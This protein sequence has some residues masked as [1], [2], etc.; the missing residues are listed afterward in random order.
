MKELVTSSG[1]HIVGESISGVGTCITLPQLDIA[2]DIGICPR[3]ALKC[4]NVLISHGHVDH[5]GAAVTHAAT[6]DLFGAPKTRFVVS[7][8]IATKLKA[9][10]DLWA[11]IQKEDLPYEVAV[12][13]PGDELRIGKFVVRP[14]ATDHVIPSQGYRVVE[15]RQ[16][17]KPEFVGKPGD[18]IGRLRKSGV[19]VTNMTEVL[20]VVY[21]GDTR[22]TVWDRVEGIG[23]AEV[24]ITEATYVADDMTPE[25]AAERGHTHLSK[26]VER[27]ERFTTEALVLTHFSA[28]YERSAVEA[29]VALVP[30]DFRRRISLL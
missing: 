15:Q 13:E 6:R 4:R 28:R 1:T 29:A 11:Q 27:A 16:K 3:W 25:V 8:E 5:L 20:R 14:F 7:S 18:E 23:S 30:E 21:T 12:V 9:L 19:E 26:L 2:F 24:V 22:P 17:L 10:F